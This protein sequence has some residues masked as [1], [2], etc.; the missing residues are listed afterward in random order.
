MASNNP[1]LARQWESATD[2][3]YVFTITSIEG[4]VRYFVEA[5][6]ATTPFYLWCVKRPPPA[7]SEFRIRYTYPPYTG[8]PPLTV[9]NNTGLIQRLSATELPPTVVASEPLQSATLTLNGQNIAMDA[10]AEENARQ[11]KLSVNRDAT[12]AIQLEGEWRD[13]GQT[14]LDNFTF[15]PRPIARRFCA[16]SRPDESAPES[17]RNISIG[18]SGAVDYSDLDALTLHGQVNDSSPIDINLDIG[19]DHRR[20]EDTLEFDLA[21]LKLRLGDVVTLAM[22]ARDNAGQATSSGPVQVLASPEVVLYVDMQARPRSWT[23]P[24]NCAAHGQRRA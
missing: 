5:G 19:P 22:T 13:T 17:H 7:V 12:Y 21:S 4:D 24:L 8:R 3:R 9:A 15:A 16:C 20:Q 18:L 11:V 23:E 1:G 10:G 6:D 2:G 14:T